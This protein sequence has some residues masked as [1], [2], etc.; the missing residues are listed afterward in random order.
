MDEPR[1]GADNMARDQALLDLAE[2]DNVSVLRLY[3]WNPHCLSFGRNEPALR[4]YDREKIHTRG[5][6]CVRRPTGG[7]A[8]WHARELTY[9]VVSPLRLFG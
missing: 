7:R 3:R 5:I 4:R 9:A 2:S 8:V 6:D 1:R